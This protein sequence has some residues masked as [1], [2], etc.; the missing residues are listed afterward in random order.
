MRGSGLRGLGSTPSSPTMENEKKPK[1]LWFRAKSYGWGW[2]PS[3][4]QGWLVLILY[5]FFVTYDFIFTDV[6]SA[7]SAQEILLNFFPR[8][9]GLTFLLIWICYKKGERPR[10][11]WGVKDIDK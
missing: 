11:R 2:T 9:A 4:W 7:V 6:P 10:W 5:C 1:K 3:S 8:F